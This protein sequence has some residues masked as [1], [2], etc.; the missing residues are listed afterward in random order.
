[1]STN[2][3]ITGRKI[4]L[5]KAEAVFI[6][7]GRKMNMITIQFGGKGIISKP[8]IRKWLLKRSKAP[9]NYVSLLQMMEYIEGPKFNHRFLVAKFFNPS[10]YP[11]D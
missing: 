8:T 5:K 11:P 6:G 4:W 7:K 2:E 10:Y 9:N 1:M 3:A